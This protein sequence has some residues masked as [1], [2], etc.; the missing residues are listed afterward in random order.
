MTTEAEFLQQLAERPFDRALRLVFADWLTEQGN[1][2]GEVISLCHRGG[3]S[4]TEKRRV[5]KLTQQHGASW[6]GPLAL[7]LKVSATRWVGG[8]AHELTLAPTAT[9]PELAAM[10]HDPRWA[11]VRSVNVPP[12]RRAADVRPL[13]Q[14]ARLSQVRRLLADA[15]VWAQLG[16]LE[17][18]FTLET[19]GLFSWGGVEA[20]EF[21]P[22]V[23]ALRRQPRKVSDLTLELQPVQVVNRYEAGRTHRVLLGQPA[24]QRWVTSV[25]LEIA[26]GVIEGAAGWLELSEHENLLD[27]WPAGRAWSV[28]Q[29]DVVYRLMRARGDAPWATLEIDATAPRQSQGLSQRLASIS[30]VLVQL[31]SLR[32]RDIELVTEAGMTLRQS[33]RDALVASVRRLGP[34]IEMHLR[35]RTVPV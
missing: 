3:L 26:H 20:E 23:N 7:N 5:Q 6:L 34:S 4:L 32:L 22:F 21:E 29:G 16:G 15:S 33:E 14:S 2:R 19:A 27:A 1:P 8:F 24:W 17:L 13:L 18:P 35:E 31:K 12:L 9:E 10:A 28:R 25:H 30:A 11:T